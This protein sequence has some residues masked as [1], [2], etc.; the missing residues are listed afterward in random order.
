VISHAQ[1]VAILKY[2]P[3]TGVFLRAKALGN[4]PAGTVAGWRCPSNGYL[5]IEIDGK[6]YAQHRLAFFYMTARWPRRVDHEDLDRTN[7]KWNNLRE[8]THSQNGANRAAQAN[9]SS[10]RKGVHWHKGARKWTAEICC[11][12]QR[13]YLGLFTTE[14]EAS[15]AY[16]AKANELFG[17][18]A[19]CD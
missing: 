14:V 1:L 4:K 15:N 8:A 5:H 12:K 3:A 11:D 16:E 13:I 2:D 6:K 10:G 17:E 19:R 9:S 18:F 7:N